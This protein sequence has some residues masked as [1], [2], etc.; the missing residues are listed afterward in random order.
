ML[1]LEPDNT[2]HPRFAKR[3]RF[4][5]GNADGTCTAGRGRAPSYEGAAADWW[6]HFALASIRRLQIQTWLCTHPGPHQRRHIA[7]ALGLQPHHLTK[8]LTAMYHSSLVTA[9]WVPGGRRADTGRL[10][11]HKW[12]WAASEDGRKYLWRYGWVTGRLVPGIWTHDDYRGTPELDPIQ[13]LAQDAR[14][15]FL[16]PVALAAAY[17]LWQTAPT[18][19][20][21]LSDTLGVDVG[22]LDR[23]L[24]AWHAEGVTDYVPGVHPPRRH[25]P[26]GPAPK[27]WRFTPHGLRAMETHCHALRWAAQHSGYTPPPDDK[28]FRNE[29][30]PGWVQCEFTAAR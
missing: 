24:H 28:F 18:T 30:G 29:E 27:K 21:F 14:A 5:R 1:I 11:R 2:P 23:F 22:S 15:S 7:A 20:R 3:H 19:T 4:G 10:Q 12:L 17:L 6:V 13:A 9:Q 25:I 16:R 26:R 8:P